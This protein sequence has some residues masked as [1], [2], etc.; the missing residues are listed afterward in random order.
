MHKSFAVADLK[1]TVFAGTLRDSCRRKPL[2]GRCYFISNAVGS[3]EAAKGESRGAV[4]TSSTCA[5][6]QKGG[7]SWKRN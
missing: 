2:A 3:W 4:R 6:S 7:D 5:F 1:P